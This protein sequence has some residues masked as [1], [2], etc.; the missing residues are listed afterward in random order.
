MTLEGALQHGGRHVQRRAHAQIRVAQTHVAD[1][2]PR[3]KARQPP[4]VRLLFA[5]LVRSVHGSS[6]ATRR[7]RRHR[8]RVKA[9]VALPQPP[10]PSTEVLASSAAGVLPASSGG[11]TPESAKS[12]TPA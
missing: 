8:C 3:M 6:I 5:T 10:P 7:T 12:H 11:T 4:T 1:S 9:R 2:A